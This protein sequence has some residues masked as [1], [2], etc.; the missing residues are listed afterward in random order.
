M[1][2]ELLSLFCCSTV[3][4]RQQCGTYRQVVAGCGLSRLSKLH[5][6]RA[7]MC[8]QLSSPSVDMWFVLLILGSTSVDM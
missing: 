3:C 2:L 1:V 4:H 6:T 5:T 8:C 7:L